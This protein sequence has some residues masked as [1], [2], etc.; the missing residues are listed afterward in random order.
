MSD[1]NQ[2]PDLIRAIDRLTVAVEGL[3]TSVTGLEGEIKAIKTD[4]QDLKTQVLVNT[5]ELKALGDKVENLRAE[6]KDDVVVLRDQQKSTDNRLWVFVAGLVTLLGG[7]LLTG[8]VRLLW[9]RQLI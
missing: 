4:V 1:P 8:L 7:S 6:I 9:V 3:Q 2:S 5:S